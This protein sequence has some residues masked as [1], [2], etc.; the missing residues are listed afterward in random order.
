MRVWRSLPRRDG[1]GSAR[2]RR[3]RKLRIARNERRSIMIFGCIIY[4]SALRQAAG[5]GAS[6]FAP[7]AG[8]SPFERPVRAARLQAAIAF[9]NRAAMRTGARM[10][11]KSADAVGHFGAQDVLEGAGVLLDGAFVADGQHIHEQALRQ[12]VAADHAARALFAARRESD[13]AARASPPGRCAPSWRTTL[14][15]CAAV[16]CS[17]SS[18]KRALARRP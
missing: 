18:W 15:C 17:G 4:A 7:A 13:L 6:H 2:Q 14:R 8:L 11:E 3:W 5:Q 9:R 16:K 1:V 10:A 12:A